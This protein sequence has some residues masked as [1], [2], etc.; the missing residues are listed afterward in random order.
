MK[1]TIYNSIIHGSLLPLTGQTPV[2]YSDTVHSLDHCP[3]TLPEIETRLQQVLAENLIVDFYD[4]S[5]VD[6]SRFLKNPVY[7][8][9]SVDFFPPEMTLPFPEPQ[10]LIQRFYFFIISA[11]AKRIKLRLRQYVETLHDD[12]CARLEIVDVLN[13]LAR[14]ARQIRENTQPDSIFDFLL[15]QIIRLYF[16][17]AFMFDRLLSQTDSLPFSD[18]F[19]PASIVRPLKSKPLPIKKPSIYTRDSGWLALSIP[20]R[21]YICFRYCTPTLQK[22]PP[23]RC[24]LL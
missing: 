9:V 23:I 22:H 5:P 17:L 12:T 10:S 1:L 7:T 15:I 19:L 6:I 13:C 2:I 4:D 18:F 3:E 20:R 14:Y 16:E 24:L 8:P 21:R 11:E